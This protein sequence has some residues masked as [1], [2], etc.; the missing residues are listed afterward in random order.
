MR[1]PMVL[2]LTVWMI[3]SACNGPIGYGSAAYETLRVDYESETTESE[4]APTLARRRLARFCTTRADEVRDQAE[5]HWT[6][7]NILLYLAIGAT[8]IGAAL[9]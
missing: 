3:G 5:S 8:G 7:D 9:Q 2:G 4:L 6:Q 1:F